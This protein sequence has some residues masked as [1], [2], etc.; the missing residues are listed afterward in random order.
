MPAAPET[1]AEAVLTAV[2]VHA[3]RV[4]DAVRRL[5]CGPG[6]AAAVTGAS[7]LDLVG[8]VANGP[9]GGGGPVGWGVAPG[10]AAGGARGGGPGGA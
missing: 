8:A 5:G 6:A 9:A 1:S 4:H 2:R 7:A 3:D 10:R